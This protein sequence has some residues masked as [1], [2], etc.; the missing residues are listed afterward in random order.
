MAHN[1]MRVRILTTLGK[2]LTLLL[3]AI[4][5]GG[6]VFADDIAESSRVSESEALFVRRVAPLLREKCLGCHGQDPELI[7]GSLD[8]RSFA[9]LEVGG[10]SGE[11]AVVPGEPEHSPLYL[12]STRTSD[13]WSEMPPK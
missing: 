7:E 6:H 8:L 4:L 5:L 2:P 10:D 3:L 12:A 9:G 11:A 1:C 13:D